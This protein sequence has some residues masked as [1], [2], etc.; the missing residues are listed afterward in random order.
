MLDFAQYLVDPFSRD[1]LPAHF[2]ASALVVDPSGEKVCLLH[3]KKLG[4]WLQPGGH[5]EPIDDGDPLRAALREAHEETALEVRLPNPEAPFPLDLDIHPIPG[6]PNKPAHEHLDLRYLFL[7]AGET[8]RFDPEESLGLRFVPWKEALALA[9]D[10]AL[11]R[12]LT[13]GRSALKSP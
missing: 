4:R 12:L 13:K 5:F 11:S 1:E 10:P 7:A 2:T 3:H 6:R 9:G 8:A